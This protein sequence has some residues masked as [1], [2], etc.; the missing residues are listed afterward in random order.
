MRK[1][2]GVRLAEVCVRGCLDVPYCWHVEGWA[3]I[4]LGH[5]GDKD[6]RQCCIAIEW[7]VR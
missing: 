3:R 7:S 4:E 2:L 6:S 5:T 1:R